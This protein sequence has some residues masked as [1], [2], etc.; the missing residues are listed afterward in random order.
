MT[1][2]VPREYQREAI[3]LIRQSFRT[4][5]RAPLY[6]A[7]TGSGKTVTFCL[8]ALSAI[9]HRRRVAIVVHRQELLAQTSRALEAIGIDHGLIAAGITPNPSALV[10][11]GMVS[12]LRRRLEQGR[13][14]AP[15]ELIIFDEGHHAVAGEWGRIRVLAP[16]A[17]ILGTTA[18]PERLDGQGLGVSF[19]GVYDD[20][21]LGPSVEA[22]M[23]DGFLT[24]AHVYAPPAL[25]D[26]E[27]VRNRG[28]DW[29]NSELANRMDRPT[30]TGDAVE[31]YARVCPGAP[32]IAFCAS[33]AHAEHV[34]QQFRAAG[35][36]ADSIDGNLSD[37]E[38]RRR[39][40]DLAEGRL[41][42][43]TSCDL[44]SEGTDIPV[45]TAAILLRP[46]Q[47]LTLHLQQVG[48]VL[49]PVYAKG[50]DLTTR[51]GRLAAIAG[52]PKRF[53]IILDHVGNLRHGLP[54]EARDWS[55]AGRPKGQRSRDPQAPALR[56]AQCPECFRAHSP[57]PVC[58]SCGHAYE[59]TIRA[60]QQVGG[61]LVA[62][63]EEH[64]EA[65]AAQRLEQKQE[66][67]RAKTLEDLQAIARARGYK[68]AWAVHVFNTRKRRSPARRDVPHTVDMLGPGE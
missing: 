32:A 8:I 25:V 57:A 40:A 21:I 23:L 26:L 15:F 2:P 55:L 39:I 27:G 1:V 61:E 20:L 51:D 14:G 37:G 11:V 16:T 35:W 12:T 22:L 49:R 42:V 13:T 41:H 53:A 9:R 29:A 28:G 38:R 24:T 56:I 66:V 30:I 34:A 31:H 17:R 3:R 19:G 44:I 67:G 65:L 43:L 46:T 59:A 68:Q 7:P 60:P 4:E 6:V 47:S 18:T 33:V 5:H 63:T 45:V 54:E 50:F 48:R 64:R 58:P 52:G 62:V 10:Q 36:K